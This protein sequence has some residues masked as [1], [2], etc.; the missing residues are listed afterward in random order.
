MPDLDWP[1]VAAASQAPPQNVALAWPAILDG[2]RRFGI[3]QPL[4]QV[5]AAATVAVETGDFTPKRERRANAK[6]QPDIYRLQER[7]WPSGFYGRG[8]LQLTWERNYRAYGEMI[9]VDLVAQPDQ[10]MAV[11]V[12]ALLLGAYFRDRSVDQ[13][14]LARD[15]PRVRKLVNGGLHGWDR[16]KAVV[17]TLTKGMA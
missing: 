6:R 9:G 15:W 10:A 8:F 1:A 13:A 11:D 3:A 5:A 7:Y 14:A 16:F 12:A 4:V 2:L 17:D